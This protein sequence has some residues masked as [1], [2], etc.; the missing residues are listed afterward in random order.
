[1]RKYKA[2]QEKKNNRKYKRMSKKKKSSRQKRT[3]FEK[4]EKI[5]KIMRKYYTKNKCERRQNKHCVKEW[6]TEKMTR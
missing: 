1:M 5:E 2:I 4:E 3:T 6:M